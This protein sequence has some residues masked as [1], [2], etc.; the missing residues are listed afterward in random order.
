MH[1][2]RA[3][4]APPQLTAAGPYDAVVDVSM[5]PSHVRRALDALTDHSPDAHW[6]FVSTIS[7][8]ADEADPAGPGQGRLLNEIAEDLD[9]MASPENYGGMKVACERQVRDTAASAAVV[10]PGLIV[11]PGDPSGRFS[12]WAR[13]SAATGP[14]LAPGDPA[15]LMQVI[16]VRDLAAWIVTLAENRTTGTYDAVAPAQPLG[17]LLAACLPDAELVWIDQTFLAAEGVQPWA[18]PESIPLWLPR[19]AYAGMASHDAG[20]ALAAGLEPRPLVETTRD[21]RAWLDADPDVQ[22]TGITTEREADLLA[23]WRDR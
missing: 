13:R 9:P 2:D 4:P 5:L 11:G 12:Y 22:I 6:V 16:D 1:W 23:R 21:T 15:D 19:P 17:E 8:Y 7:V 10:R 20:P 3:E 18:G 14:V